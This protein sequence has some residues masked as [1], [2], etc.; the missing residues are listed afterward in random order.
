MATWCKARAAVGNLN[1]INVET[2]ANGGPD[3]QVVKD[4]DA[5]EAVIP[6]ERDRE[7]HRH[8][9]NANPLPSHH[10]PPYDSPPAG[11]PRLPA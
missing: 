9:N 2:K 5:D 7:F 1:E 3:T 6:I 10:T 4:I 11:A 8:I